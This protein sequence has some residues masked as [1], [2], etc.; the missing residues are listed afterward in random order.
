[1][2]IKV[3][4]KTVRLPVERLALDH[5]EISI[6]CG[7]TCHY[8]VCSVIATADVQLT[9]IFTTKHGPHLDLVGEFYSDFCKCVGKKW[10]LYIDRALHVVCRHTPGEP[11][12]CAY[13]KAMMAI[14]ATNMMTQNESTVTIAVKILSI[15]VAIS[16]FASP[17]LTYGPVVL[18]SRKASDVG[19]AAI[20]MLEWCNFLNIYKLKEKKSGR[21]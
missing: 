15:F 10:T 14:R 12:K 5:Q 13:P 3:A 20:V 19:S 11:L 9:S 21:K 8:I 16:V 7:A 4:T 1:M 2:S 18:A 17:S 6:C